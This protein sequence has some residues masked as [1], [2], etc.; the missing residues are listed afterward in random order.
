MTEM[1]KTQR[2]FVKAALHA[3]FLTQ[4][5]EIALAT[6]WRENGDEKALHKLTEAHMRLVI[7]I[8]SRFRH[9][10]LP[11][12]DLI[13]EGHLGLLQAANRF[14]ISREVRFSTY[15]AWW[16]RA[17]MQDYILR[18]WSIVRS[19]TSSAQKSLFFNLRRLRAK[20][21]QDNETSPSEVHEQISRALG[22]SKSDVEAMD[23]RLS[24]GDFSL[25]MELSEE[26]G[27]SEHQDFLIDD[28]QNPEQQVEKF[29]D[30]GRRKNWLSAALSKLNPREMQIIKAR[31]LDD[32]TVTLEEMG[33]RLGVSKERVR[34]I[35]NRA[36]EKL[37]TSLTDR[38][39]TAQNMMA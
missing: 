31:K 27:S 21:S 32:E 25:N 11:A 28:T 30:D 22:V 10:G 14:E 35:E 13:Q 17:A 29:L 24:R 5:E 9:Y 6:R 20:L 33:K 8:A 37:R 15:A 4:E 36:L 34:Q 2:Q 1:C 19:G 16:V 23:M 12:V 3:P 39:L 7:A 38:G 26:E 18:N